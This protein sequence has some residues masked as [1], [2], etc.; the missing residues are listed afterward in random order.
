MWK[1][2]KRTNNNKAI[3]PNLSIMGMEHAQY[4]FYLNFYRV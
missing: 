3:L 4:A 1:R 2:K